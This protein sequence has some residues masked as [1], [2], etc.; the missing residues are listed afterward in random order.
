MTTN[1]QKKTSSELTFFKEKQQTID[2]ISEVVG[3]PVEKKAAFFD[4]RLS[5]LLTIL[6]KY[7]EQSQL[8]GP[9]VVDL[10]NPINDGLLRYLNEGEEVRK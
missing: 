7:Q 5:R 8:L 6:D 1:T 2:I 9:H 10:I 3:A 4:E